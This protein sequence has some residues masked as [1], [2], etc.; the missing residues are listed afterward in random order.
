[1]IGAPL[2][3][4]QEGDLASGGAGGEEL[5]HGRGRRSPVRQAGGGAQS[6]GLP[7]LVRLTHRQ[8]DYAIRDL[9]GIDSGVLSEFL[10]DQVFY[11]FDNNASH[12]EVPTTRP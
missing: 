9:L 1:M 2:G 10:A 11:G 4:G 6:R 7:N 12:L 5:R 3:P 8:Y